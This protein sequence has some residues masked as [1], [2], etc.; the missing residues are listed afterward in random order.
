VEEPIDISAI[1]ENPTIRNSPEDRFFAMEVL[2]KAVEAMPQQQVECLALM[3]AGFS[4]QEIAH[5][6]GLSE[7][8]VHEYL[9]SAFE[10]IRTIANE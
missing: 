3:L 7:R 10:R 6:L 5:R 1:P 2:S 4:E 9:A 8:M